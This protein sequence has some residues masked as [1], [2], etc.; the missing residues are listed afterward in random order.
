MDSM[1]RTQRT[2][3]ALI[4]GAALVAALPAP[5]G[6]APTRIASGHAQGHD[7]CAPPTGVS[8]ADQGCCDKAPSSAETVASTVGPDAVAP[9]AT[10]LRAVPAPPAHRVLAHPSAPPAPSPPPTVL[11]V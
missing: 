1:S 11:R 6:C 9:V 4:A 10:L 3:A 5:C 7:C 2:A 8:A